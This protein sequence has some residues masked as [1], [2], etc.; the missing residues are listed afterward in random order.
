MRAVV[1]FRGEQAFEVDELRDEGL[2]S[3]RRRREPVEL[4]RAA[5]QVGEDKRG[6]AGLI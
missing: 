4:A 1:P 5:E 2:G 3:R 6:P